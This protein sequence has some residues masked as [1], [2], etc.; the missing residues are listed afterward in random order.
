LQHF[1]QLE[2]GLNGFLFAAE[3]SLFLPCRNVYPPLPAYMY[4]RIKY[5]SDH[6]RQMKEKVWNNSSNKQNLSTTYFIVLFINKKSV[7]Q[8]WKR[9]QERNRVVVEKQ[10]LKETQ[11]L[12]S[13]NVHDI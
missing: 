9:E 10:T 12:Q 8:N 11:T 4:L 13:D 6:S 5:V 1:Y 7:R 3:R 2:A